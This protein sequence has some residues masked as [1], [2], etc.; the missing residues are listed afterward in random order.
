MQIPEES[1][2]RPPR[3]ELFRRALHLH[4][5]GHI[6]GA[7]EL[8]LD[9]L[10]RD[11]TH[12]DSLHLLG[13]T[14][15]QSGE[16][17][18]GIEHIR[19]ATELNPGFG[20][21]HYNLGNALLTLK[22]PEQALTSFAEALRLNPQDA[23]YHLE[24]GNALK[25]LGRLAEAITSFQNAVRLAGRYAE[26]HNNLGIV[27]KE[28][29]R[30]DEALQ[31]YDA[32]I[33][34][35]PAYAEA[36]SNRG[37]ALRDAGRLDEALA[38]HDR[39]IGLKP[40]YAEAHCNRGIVLTELKRFEE[41]LASIE[42]SIRLKPEH[43]EAWNARGSALKG[44]HRFEQAMASYD[45]AIRLKPDYAEAYNNRGLLLS[46][47]ERPDEALS[48]YDQAIALKP[49]YAEAL[50][51]KSYLLLHR[52]QFGEGFALYRWRWN[53]KGMG[54][55]P[56]Y[57]SLPAWDGSPVSGKLL[58]W[59]EQGLGDEVLYA[60]L[61]SLISL[62][63]K[64]IALTA[65]KRLQPLYKRAFPALQLLD[66]SASSEAT[67]HG[68][69]A[70]AAIGDLGAILKIDADKLGQRR[71]P[72]LLPDRDRTREI[73]SAVPVRGE[74][75]LCGLSWRSANKRFGDEKSIRLQD[76]APLLALPGFSFVNLQYGDVGPEIDE[77]GKKLGVRVHQV[78]GLDVFN[79]IDGLLSLIDACDVLLTT[80]NVTAHLAGAM[81]KRAVVLVPT[82]RGRIWYWQGEGQN[83]WY[84][85][86]TLIP[87]ETR[88]E[89]EKPIQM[90]TSWI[91]DRKWQSA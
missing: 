4:Q 72:F 9:L 87:Q 5:N 52:G 77:A 69:S 27:L 40:N 76:L 68:F 2:P 66:R 13:L 7:R 11:P 14:Y 8:Y 24:H 39:A 3:E 71:Y 80:C 91:R 54:E 31:S 18:T 10:K 62:P 23:Q 60:S 73:R 48:S 86:L 70:Q 44:L 78:S 15:V 46:D 26:A 89:W 88:G 56:P 41:A 33:R 47:F 1:Q 50:G 35:Q 29:G 51:N 19:K 55:K 38:S 65:D 64:D 34:L 63:V 75:V 90:A 74:A 16:A 82:A 57:A 53:T 32:A 20:E 59:A 79:D 30:T 67:D 42:Q 58:L 43:A 25:E 45:K 17:E 28:A 85:S 81:G 22:R 6:R 83:L 49:D 61:L 36:H 12:A 21:A 84:P 37:N